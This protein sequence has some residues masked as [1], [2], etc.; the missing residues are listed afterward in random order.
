MMVDV[1]LSVDLALSLGMGGLVQQTNCH[2]L[3][4]GFGSISDPKLFQD[5]SDMSLDRTRRDE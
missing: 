5:M 1:I 4:Y 2:R 3:S